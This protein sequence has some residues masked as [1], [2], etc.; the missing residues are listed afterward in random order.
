VL[1]VS[2]YVRS[3]A[4]T[5]CDKASSRAALPVEVHQLWSQL[6]SPSISAQFMATPYDPRI[7]P[8]EAGV[9]EHDQSSASRTMDQVMKYKNDGPE[10]QLFDRAMSD[11]GELTNWPCLIPQLLLTMRLLLSLTGRSKQHSRQKDPLRHCPHTHGLAAH[12]MSSRQSTAYALPH[13]PTALPAKVN[14]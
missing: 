3:R 14:H 7:E 11:K 1:L 5:T 9:Q 13:L 8:A 12:I 10:R 4:A 2:K 6:A